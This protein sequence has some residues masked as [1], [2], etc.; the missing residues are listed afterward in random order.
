MKSEVLLIKP[1][2]GDIAVMPPL[3]LGYLAAVLG[4]ARISCRI[5]DNTLFEYDDA[6]LISSRCRRRC[7]GY[8][9]YGHA[10]FR[11]YCLPS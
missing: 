4:A 6:R 7:I 8:S 9:F 10:K 11:F 1:D 5:H 2:F 3:G